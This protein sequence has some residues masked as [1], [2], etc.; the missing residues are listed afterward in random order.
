MRISCNWLNDYLPVKLNSR[1]LAEILTSIGLEV[2]SLH[3]FGRPPGDLEGLLIG[4]V[5]DVLPHPRADKLKITR[6]DCGS[7]DLLQIVCGA[8]NVAV[9]QKV[10]VAIPGTTLFPLH[11]DPFTLKVATIRGVESY[12]M[13]CAEDEIGLG[14]DHSGIMVLDAGALVGSAVKDYFSPDH[15]KVL[16]IGLTPNRTACMSHIGIARELCAF[17][18]N[19]SKGPCKIILPKTGSLAPVIHELAIDIRIDDPAACR[20]YAGLTIS[21]VKIGASP[22]WLSNR[23]KALGIRPICNVVDLAN[24]IL[25]ECG[26]PL[27]VFDADRITGRR[28]IVR[29]LK[30]GTP[31]LTLD[32]KEIKLDSGDLMICDNSGPIC[33]AGIFG[34]LHSGVSPD[35]VNIFLESAWF[36]PARIRRS[37]L[38]HG[39]RTDAA[40]RFEKGADISL[41]PFSLQRAASLITDLAGGRVSSALMDVYPEPL[42]KKQVRVGYDYLRRLS[43]QEY[44]KEKIQD[45]LTGLGFEVAERD[46]AG[47]RVE[48]PYSSPDISGEADIAEEI[49][50]IDGLDRI[51]VPNRVIFA[52]GSGTGADKAAIRDRALDYLAALGFSEIITNSITNSRYF[53]EK[54]NPVRLIN[55]LSSDLDILRPSML[56]SGL[57]VITYNLNHKNGDLQ[58]FDSG[59]VYT[60]PADRYLE[61]EQLCLYLT[62]NGTENWTGI[63]IKPD[64]YFLKGVLQN[65]FSHLGAGDISLT[66]SQYPGLSVVCEISIGPMVAGIC[67]LV[68]QEKIKQFDI[69]QEVW[70]AS[71]DWEEVFAAVS[72][73]STRFKPLDRFPAVRRDLSLVLDQ[74][75]RYAAVEQ[76]VRQI[77][78]LRHMQLFDVFESEK[79][80]PG[81]KAYAISFTFQDESRTLNEQDIESLMQQLSRT[82]TR[83]LGAEYRK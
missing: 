16:E 66:P 74:D 57:E 77:P 58:L 52:P 12:G 18:N 23:L 47:F 67:G 62:G 30:A 2:E 4:Q 50:R 76:A 31:F 72:A 22:R 3:S 7:G 29:T 39:L 69:R 5:M 49:M 33:M 36:D 28:I 60:H 61:Q 14:E 80:G 10:V 25:H 46:P 53:K 24:F 45:I 26:Q 51:P 54:P 73:G 42:A 6:V 48:V 40:L 1:E 20:R 15:D 75:T 63:S 44:G 78:L 32:G 11:A 65:L 81:K 38:L 59:K 27:H 9:D 70:Y 21:G 55:A 13:I 35:T 83:E 37:S 64:F 19:A 8:P 41:I 68:S 43:G 34:G 56:E 79:L 17:L 71:L 82:L